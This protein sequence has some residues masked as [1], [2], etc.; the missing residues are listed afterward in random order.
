MKIYLLLVP[1]LAFMSCNG[2]KGT[3]SSSNMPPQSDYR[4]ERPTK[5]VLF[6]FYNLENLFDTED[7]PLTQD[8]DFTPSGKNRWTPER[9]ERKL[10]NISRA[11][12]T[13]NDGRG[14]DVIGVCEVENAHV[15]SML[16]NDHLPRGA[17][18]IVHTDSPDERGIDVAILYRKSAV[19]LAS[20]TVHRVDLGPGERPTR[21]ILEAT[22]TRDGYSFTTL[23]NHWPSRRGG[24]SASA[25]KREN[26]AQ[27]AAAIIDSLERLDSAADIVLMGDL[28][29][30][31]FDHSVRGVLDADAWSGSEPF[32]HRMINT[33]M[34]VADLNEI[35]T[36]Y[37]Q[38]AWEVID[39]IMLSR[40][41]LDGRGLT[42]YQT[43]ETVFAPEFLRD[44]RADPDDRPP[45]RTFKGSFQY[46]GGT[47]DHFPV[48]L[49]VGG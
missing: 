45:Y 48:L 30:T 35:G 29:D 20:T 46:I 38:H 5:S 19:T 7:D 36:Y 33:A 9:M 25:W 6:A 21:D 18:G 13:M 49:E 10:E 12:M 28:N 47:S 14:P 44:L 2:R 15:L 39:Q 23:V 32:R 42:L 1:L 22:F 43:A 3:S 11:L 8:D 41:A 27:V 37:Y 16:V 17:Y 40:G 31:P 4:G 26:A 34:P 24:E